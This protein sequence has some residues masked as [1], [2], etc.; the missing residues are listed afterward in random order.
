MKTQ[1]NYL[2][3]ALVIGLVTSSLLLL[4]AANCNKVNVLPKFKSMR[5]ELPSWALGGHSMDAKSVDIDKDGDLDLIV[6]NEFNH[7][8][9]LINDGQGNLS[10]GTKDR[11]P[12]NWHDSEDI[13][14]GDFDQ[15][16]DVDIIF[17]SE[18]DKV[19]EYY[20]NNGK[21]FFKAAPYPLLVTGKSNAVITI[22]LDK[23][24]D[25]DLLI[26]N[27]GQNFA[28][29]NNGQGK[30]TDVTRKILPVGTQ[31]TQ[32]LELGDVDLDG[33]LD[34]IVGNEGD[35]QL[36]INNGQGVFKDETAQRLPLE[37]GQEE[38]RE[39][40]FGDVDGDG[41]LD[42]VFANVNFKQSKNSQNRL[43]INNGKGMF[44][45]ETKQ[46]LPQE[47]LH[48]VDADL[49]DIDGDKDLDLLIGNGFGKKGVQV[50]INN[51]KGIFKD[52]TTQIVKPFFVDTIDI[53]VADFN[54][55]GL[56]DFYL[57]NFQ[58]DDKLFLQIQ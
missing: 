21:G 12:P 50:L 51:G 1:K 2:K 8:I 15:D 23:D 49:V 22:D 9:I 42:I 30:F 44:K 13:A 53:E 27:D 40:D 3:Y 39:A 46:R 38:T 16:G 14:L 28:L 25:L 31:T 47:K 19:N 24:G 41:D 29:L 6:A 55:D 17:V 26:G 34:L 56:P 58:G 45:D 33:D 4:I 11:L 57:C 35:N 36:L 48:S 18:D 37:A 5:A 20:W 32:D 43:L 10:D 52:Q 7:N 54:A